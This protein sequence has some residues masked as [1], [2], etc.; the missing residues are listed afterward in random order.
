MDYKVNIK[1]ED[2]DFINPNPP[3]VFPYNLD[4]FQKNAVNSIEEGN[5]VLVTAHTSAGKSTVAE[6]AISKAL[7]E[8]K[9][10][11][12]TSPIKTLSN[13]KY[14][15]FKQS[16]ESVG[17]LTGDIKENPEAD[18]IVM[19]TEIL[20][21]MLF[22]GNEF[23]SELGYVIFDEIHYIND[24]D[25][26]HVWEE[27]IVMLPP[28]IKL[29]MLSATI[30]NSE[31]FANW[32]ANIKKHNVDLISTPHRPVPLKHYIFH[33]NDIHLILNQKNSFDSVKY[34]EICGLYNKQFKNYKSY[35]SSFN[36]FIK[37][38]EE[39]NLFPCIF[40][41]FSR[42]KCE[43]YAKCLVPKL[44]SFEE[45]NEI[46]KIINK[47]MT[48]MFKEYSK[49]EQTITLTNLLQ[50]G[51]GFHHSGLVHPL[52]EIQEI[53]FSKGLIKILFATETFSVG[54]NMP[55]RTV[56]FTE[57]SKFDGHSKSLRNLN[58]SEYIQMAGRSGRR[59]KDA[60]GTVIYYPM[61]NILETY[62]IK[63][64]M[65][66]ST[67]K[68]LSKLKLNTQFLL[69]VLQSPNYDILD[70]INESLLGKED[71]NVN[72]QLEIK[73]KK[74]LESNE[75][76]QKLLEMIKNKEE[77]ERYF[78]LLN[79]I[80]SSRGNKRKKIERELLNLKQDK[81]I[82]VDVN[83]QLDYNNSLQEA[84][85]VKKN[86]DSN[87]LHLELEVSKRYLMDVEFI[88]KT[89]KSLN[90]LDRSDLTRKGLIGSEINECNEILLTEIIDNDLLNELSVE[91]ICGVLGIFIESKEDNLYNIGELEIS[92]NVKDVLG[93][94][95]EINISLDE[96]AIKH[97]I[98]YDPYITL[99]SVMVV[100]QWAR[101]DSLRDIYLKNSLELYE[102]NFVKNITKVLNICNE[103]V[104]VCE[105]VGKNILV[106]KLQNIESL[107][108]RD[109]VSFDSIYVS[110]NP[111]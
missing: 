90:E 102:G 105:L 55:T 23:I 44:T 1:T 66:G 47:Y 94:I 41:S 65:L 106:E 20:R 86:I 91:E 110:N 13:Q 10:V 107:L 7:S 81:K 11:V 49:L 98:D 111:I 108:L 37:Y 57:L 50:K 31:L 8:G 80:G 29:I 34:Q 32:I 53:L 82:M 63:S 30:S 79:S 75:N 101:G 103:I 12:Y 2:C 109:I 59:G 87:N 51:Y 17:I 56:V 93:Q 54:V 22:R 78:E 28:H 96:I 24:R 6:Y 104:H 58:T 83:L 69:K 84:M 21:N 61:R 70:F 5:H 9:K 46:K 88:N 52:K 36:E 38:L 64:M 4:I 74:L 45:E 60:N 35:K 3:I 100:Y 92:D 85:I 18:C 25:R 76:K 95:S 67:T 89:S 99:N 40:F 14:Y 71:S 27:T 43:E 72:E 16:Y 39:K 33:N 77:V 26:G 15:D 62:E 42:K 48:G 19:T 97:N 73:Y 68:I